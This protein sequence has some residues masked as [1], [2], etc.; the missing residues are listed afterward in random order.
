MAIDR[1]RSILD[2]G[3]VLWSIVQWATGREACFMLQCELTARGSI[4]QPY[5]V[6]TCSVARCGIE[7]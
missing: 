6:A 2:F 7:L 5:G 4:M 1:L 3:L